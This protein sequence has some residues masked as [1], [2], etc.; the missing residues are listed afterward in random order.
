MD[1]NLKK[2]INESSMYNLFCLVMIGVVEQGWSYMPGWNRN[3]LNT[4]ESLKSKS[5]YT[6]QN[7]K[8]CQFRPV[9]F[10]VLILFVSTTKPWL[11]QVQI[12]DLSVHLIFVQFLPLA[13]FRDF[14]WDFSNLFYV[15]VLLPH[16]PPTT[17]PTVQALQ[18]GP[19]LF[20]IRGELFYPIS[21][22]CK[23]LCYKIYLR[24][25]I[26]LRAKLLKLSN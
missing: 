23:E 2:R 7:F 10:V 14:E 15:C 22:I 6:L 16:L 8:S 13:L 3:S 9:S 1:G 20:G 21:N 11:S 4:V 5:D 12:S 17:S 18:Y 26:N 19:D 24:F 25:W